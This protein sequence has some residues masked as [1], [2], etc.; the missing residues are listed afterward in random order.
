MIISGVAKSGTD[1]EAENN[2]IKRV[3]EVLNVL[4]IK[5]T[6]VKRQARLKRKENA[7]SSSSG[8]NE[9]IILELRSMEVKQ[10]ACSNARRLR[11]H[12]SLN[13]IYVN[14]DKTA[15]QRDAERILRKERNSRNDCLGEIDEDGRRFGIED[16]KKF[17]WAI[18]DGRVRKVFPRSA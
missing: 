9:L 12:S 15:A 1:Q 7:A 13:G 8:G 18:R 6:D 2:D 14:E 4:Q 5:R 17:C 10:K 3:D 16:G 11:Q